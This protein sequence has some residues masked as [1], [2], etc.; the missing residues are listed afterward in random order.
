MRRWNSGRTA[1]RPALR[2][3]RSSKRLFLSGALPDRSEHHENRRFKVFLR[4]GFNGYVLRVF[5]CTSGVQQRKGAPLRFL[6]FVFVSRHRPRRVGGPVAHGG[7]VVR[8]RRGV[9]RGTESHGRAALHLEG[10]LVIQ[11]T[12][13]FSRHPRLRVVRAL[14]VSRSGSAE[15]RL[16]RHPRGGLE[17]RQPE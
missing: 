11:R 17:E 8:P 15:K 4:V 10:M 2:A 9:I 5:F 7:V 16:L 6:V 14:R 12:C 13:A 3:F 1:V